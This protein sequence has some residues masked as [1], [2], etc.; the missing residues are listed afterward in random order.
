MS[1]FLK[2]YTTPILLVVILGLQVIY[3]IENQNMKFMLNTI[4][5]RIDNVTQLKTPLVNCQVGAPNEIISTRTATETMAA[6]MARHDT[7]VTAAKAHYACN[8][9]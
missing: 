1:D 8:N 2:K 7:D 4:L 6:F 9:P 5:E 3:T